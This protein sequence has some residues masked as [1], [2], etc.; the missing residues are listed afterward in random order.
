MPPRLLVLLLPAACLNPTTD[1][2][3]T[4]PSTTTSTSETSTQPRASNI[5]QSPKDCDRSIRNGVVVRSKPGSGTYLS[6][7]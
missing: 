1:L 2:S 5:K 6:S 7:R 3:T 4:D